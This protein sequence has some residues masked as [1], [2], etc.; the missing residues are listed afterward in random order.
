ML[1]VP[2]EKS[3]TAA[4]RA[5]QL[6]RQIAAIDAELRRVGAVVEED[7]REQSEEPAPSRLRGR[8]RRSA[9]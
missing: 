8:R 3:P 2:K 5:T 7:A 4:G 1:W 6:E 9:P